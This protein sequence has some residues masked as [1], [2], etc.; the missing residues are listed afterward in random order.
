MASLYERDDS[1]IAR[2]GTIFEFR[3]VFWIEPPVTLVRDINYTTRQASIYRHPQWPRNAFRRSEEYNQEDVLARAKVRYVVV[4][5]PDHEATARQIRQLVVAPI[6]GLAGR[7]DL[8]ERIKGGEWP[9][10]MYL[11][12]DDEYAELSE[13][14]INFRHVQPMV[15]ELLLSQ[16]K[17]GF[18]FGPTAR[19]AVIK[20]YQDYFVYQ[21]PGGSP[22]KA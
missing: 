22:L 9:E 5:S 4:L 1:S 12:V 2:Q 8:A 20:R 21:P 7:P 15:K 16:H 14:Y 18:R 3:P 10:Q 17:L 13:S 11:P 19:L 6:Y